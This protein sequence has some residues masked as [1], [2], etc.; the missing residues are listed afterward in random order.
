MGR[1]VPYVHGP[2]VSPTQRHFPTIPPHCSKSRWQQL[3]DMAAEEDEEEEEQPPPPPRRHDRPH[4]NCDTAVFIL[5]FHRGEP[6][7]ALLRRA[8]AAAAA[9]RAIEQ[10]AAAAEAE[11]AGTAT[12]GGRA[13]AEAMMADQ[14]DHYVHW[15]REGCVCACV[16][17]VS[18]YHI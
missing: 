11:A 16:C 15:V 7:L 14:T 6:A 2:R 3:Q 9:A 5:N 4:R 13:A 18:M 17:V 8:R 10:T 1:R 12:G